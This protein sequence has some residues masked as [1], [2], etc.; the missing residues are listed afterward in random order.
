M[1]TNRRSIKRVST[2]PKQITKT[3]RKEK[4]VQELIAEVKLFNL[5][6]LKSEQIFSALPPLLYLSI[7]CDKT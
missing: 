6:T 3:N 5:Q 7:E 4:H 1:K 2:T